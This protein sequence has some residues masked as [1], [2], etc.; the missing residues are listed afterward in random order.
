LGRKIRESMPL[1]KPRTT[2]WP[3]QVHIYVYDEEMFLIAESRNRKFDLNDNL[4][5]AWPE[6]YRTVYLGIKTGSKDWPIWD[7]DSLQWIET[8]IKYDLKFD[9][10]E[11]IVS[12]KTQRIGRPCTE[13]FIW[14]LDIHDD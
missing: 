2:D 13:E 14:R 9:V 11:V 8:L 10:N 5:Q 6:Y 12:R 1:R 3:P 7:E 4:F